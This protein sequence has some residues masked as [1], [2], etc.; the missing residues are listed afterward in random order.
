[1]NLKQTRPLRELLTVTHHTTEST[2]AIH[3]HL[4]SSFL[5][6]PFSVGSWR[7]CCFALRSVRSGTLYTFASRLPKRTVLAAVNSRDPVPCTAT[8][9]TGANA[10]TITGSMMVFGGEI[11]TGLDEVPKMTVTCRPAPAASASNTSGGG[12]GG[13]TG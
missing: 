11:S 13:A 4:L 8:L 12:G 9:G 1:M 6:L 7:L 5:D 10:I 3:P 2:P